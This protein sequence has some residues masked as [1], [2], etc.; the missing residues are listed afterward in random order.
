MFIV[1][2]STVWCLWK[3]LLTH[4]LRFLHC[5]SKSTQSFFYLLFPA[6]TNIHLVCHSHL[7]FLTCKE[8]NVRLGSWTLPA[9]LSNVRIAINSQQKSPS[10]LELY[11]SSTLCQEE[12]N[13]KEDT[14]IQCLCV[15]VSRNPHHHASL[16]YNH[17]TNWY[18][19][20]IKY[21]WANEETKHSICKL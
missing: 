5:R 9:S 7:S 18:K 15:C 11:L 16:V 2:E 14:E 17:G 4:V 1:I 12:T 8:G 19:N 21:I 10:P 3:L 6:A 13:N 20:S